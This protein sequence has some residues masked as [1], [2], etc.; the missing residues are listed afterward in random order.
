MIKESYWVIQQWIDDMTKRIVLYLSTIT[1]IVI[2]IAVGGFTGA[3]FWIPSWYGWGFLI[4][5]I[6]FTYLATFS[7]YRVY[8]L[9]TQRENYHVYGMLSL[10][11]LGLVFVVILRI[12]DSP[13][14]EH[15]FT[16]ISSS[17]Q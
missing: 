14:Q 8:L 1:F 15:G 11:L 3:Y 12:Y 2:S 10:F 16:N 4:I 5:G 7:T 17:K 9:I 13:R 6:V